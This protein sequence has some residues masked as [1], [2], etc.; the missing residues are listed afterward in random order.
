MD[1]RTF[2]HSRPFAIG[3]FATPTR[4]LANPADPGPAARISR[5]PTNVTSAAPT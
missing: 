5:R 3:A 1:R 2:V 4:W